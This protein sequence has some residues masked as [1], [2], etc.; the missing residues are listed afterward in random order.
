MDIAHVRHKPP[1]ELSR[2]RE[3]IVVC[4]PFRSQINLSRL[5]R[6]AGCFGVKRVIACGHAKLDR[7]ISRDGAES[8][9]LEV[10]RSL[11]PVLDR[12]VED[13][14]HTVGVEQ[15]NSSV[16]IFDFAFERRSAIVLGNERLG[17][18]DDELKRMRSVVEIPVYG[19]PHS[20]NVATAGALALYEY[21][22]QF[23]LG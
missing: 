8:V 2:P 23:P 19:L 4:A 22:R 16:S 11:V 20:H 12:L 18:G 1:I 5:I 21:C 9:E 17:L 7:K 6:A 15:T 3:L 10:R 13:G 14:F